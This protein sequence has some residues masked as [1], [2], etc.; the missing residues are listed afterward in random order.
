MHHDNHDHDD[1]HTELAV[2]ERIHQK[3]TRTHRKLKGRGYVN[4]DM[5][6]AERW[7]SRRYEPTESEENRWTK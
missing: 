3:A 1:I 4:M 6:E 2:D 7:E 5:Y